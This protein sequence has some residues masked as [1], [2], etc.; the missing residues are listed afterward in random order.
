[1]HLP[2]NIYIWNIYSMFSAIFCNFLIFKVTF[3]AKIQFEIVALEKFMV[4]LL[5]TSTKSRF[6]SSKSWTKNLFSVEFPSLVDITSSLSWCPWR[7]WKGLYGALEFQIRLFTGWNFKNWSFISSTFF[8]QI[9]NRKLKLFICFRGTT[10]SNVSSSKIFLQA[11]IFY[12][13]FFMPCCFNS[14][15]ALL[16]FVKTC[17]FSTPLLSGFVGVFQVWQDNKYLIQAKDHLNRSQR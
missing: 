16:L 2:E 11:H 10:F 5:L 14:G 3:L 6:V 8:S 7:F 1:M 12:L 17:D 15:V 4:T 13:I 9:L